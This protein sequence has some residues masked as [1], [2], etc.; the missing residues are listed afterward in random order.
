[1]RLYPASPIVSSNTLIG[2]S[3]AF[4]TLAL[5]FGFLNSSTLKRLRAELV[6]LSAARD[7]AL[8]A[9]TTVEQKLKVRE[10][11]FSAAKRNAAAAEEKANGAQAQLA[12]AQDEKTELEAK[13]QANE[14][15]IADL[16]KRIAEATVSAAT[17]AEP[18]SPTDLKAE[19]ENVR[20]QL[21]AAEKEKSIFAD[22]VKEAQNRVTA[23]EE[24]KEER[25]A[26]AK[27]PGLHGTVLAV[28]QA[29]NFVVLDLGNRQGVE[30]NAEMLVLRRGTLI[31]RIRISSVE[32]TTSI[33]DIIVNSLAR[34]VQVQPG[35][36]VIYAGSTNS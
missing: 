30:P 25:H 18:G 31:G 7:V 16:Q 10:T 24:E 8:H 28:N 17:A 23:M 32:P 22:K 15:E 19:L 33:G 14:N 11:E 27:A 6:N 26:A 12:K 35:D 4:L 2:T 1:M 36:T 34:G 3:L 21:E 20:H 13:L 9:R 5:L 29:Y